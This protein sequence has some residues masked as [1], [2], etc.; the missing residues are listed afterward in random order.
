[1][2][3]TLLLL[4]VALSS[5]FNSDAQ[6]STVA[7]KLS[8]LDTIYA[9]V[10][11]DK[12]DKFRQQYFTADLFTVSKY[13][14][15]SGLILIA[16]KKNYWLAFEMPFD[17]FSEKNDIHYNGKYFY[18]ET[19]FHHSSRGN[20]IANRY[21]NIIDP[22]KGFYFELPVMINQENYDPEI[23]DGKSEIKSCNC[24]IV[25]EEDRVT[26]F[27]FTKTLTD[28]LGSGVYQIDNDKLIRCR[29]YDENNYRM[30][31]IRWA[32]K[33]ATWMT[34]DD[35]TAVYPDAVV[36]KIEDRFGSC[37]E[38]ERPAYSLTDDA[39][40][41]AF[42]FLDTDEKYIRKILVQSPKISCNNIHTGMTA[43]DV[44][45]LYPAA[46]I[47]TD[48]LGDYEYIV[49]RDPAVRLIF[50]TTEKN[51]VAKYRNETMT[52]LQRPAAK[53][54]YIEIN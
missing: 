20:L 46:T 7:E 26:S 33:L 15:L 30:S 21:L 16:R 18:Y 42:L 50:N 49:L 34:L 53:I 25:L 27:Q 40:S 9:Q 39:D 44:L 2:R 24:K 43:G 51:R 47:V 8:V 17:N 41:L 31:E 10:E 19:T 38:D 48:L 1:M 12:L 45:H 54:D 23:N 13:R 36:S 3:K 4:C 29:F 28:C 52:G 35:V 22:E 37:A 6:F 32:G 5:F 11:I 14:D